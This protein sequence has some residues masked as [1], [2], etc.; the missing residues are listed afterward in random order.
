MAKNYIKTN[1][2]TAIKYFRIKRI[3]LRNVQNLSKQKL[4]KKI[5]VIGTG[6]KKIKNHLVAFH[7]EAF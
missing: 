6:S 5:H 1:P 4:Y 7:G 3:K 2:S